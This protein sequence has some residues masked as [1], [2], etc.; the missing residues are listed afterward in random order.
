MARRGREGFNMK[1]LGGCGALIS[2]VGFAVV[3]T[4]ACLRIPSAEPPSDSEVATSVVSGGLNNTTGSG[5]AVNA[6]APPSK[7][8]F[9]R[10][11]DAVN[12]IGTA[13]AAEWSCTGGSLS[14]TFSGPGADPYE[15][16]PVGCSVTWGNGRTASSEWSGPFTLS[17]G[18]SCDST[19]PIVENQ[20]GGCAVTRTTSA[21][22]ET[23]KITGP[24]GNSYAITHDTDGAGTGWD[25]SVSPAPGNGGVEVT[26]ASGGCASGRTLVVNGSHLTGTVTIDGK[27]TTIWDHTVTTSAGGI[28]V[29][30]EG[31]GR[32]VSGVVTVQHNLAKY[33]ATATF[34]S[35]GYGEP[36]CCFP[37]S[38][39]VTTTFSDG[40]DQGKTESLTFSPVC[41]D[42]TLTTASGTTEALT[43]QHCL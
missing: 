37:T 11:V 29:T 9:E 31:A 13:W 41:G 26:C 19:H 27:Q 4:P 6:P 20:A 34:D 17:Y 15:Y 24:D 38:G 10:V 40:P 16:T 14:P 1:R 33:T 18:A 12:P 43:L 5:V 42:A 3:L 22:G 23:R 7:S 28:T 8:M 21:G 2:G 30:G 35:V 36:G 32:I 25:P 39:S